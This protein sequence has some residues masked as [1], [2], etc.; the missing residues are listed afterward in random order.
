VLNDQRIHRDPDGPLVS[1]LVPVKL[2]ED[3]FRSEDRLEAF[4]VVL[5]LAT[6]KHNATE[7]RKEREYRFYL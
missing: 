6:A 4:A 5:I 2:P 7:D 3:N 1:P